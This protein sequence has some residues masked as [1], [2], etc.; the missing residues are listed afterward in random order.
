MKLYQDR[1][2]LNQK[3]ITERLSSLK[4]A[5]IC[6]VS[7]KTI[8]NWLK[9]FNIKSR[10]TSEACTGLKKGPRPQKVKEKISKSSMGHSV[11]Q[12]TRKKLSKFF[13]GR[14]RY[15]GFS[16]KHSERMKNFYKTP[17]GYLHR[18]K[19]S[20]INKGA[21]SATWKGGR[22]IENG[23]ILIKN[24]EHSSA[25]K[26]GYIPEHRLIAEKALGRKLK[27]NELPHHINFDR[28]DNRNSNLLICTFDYNFWLHKKIK[29]LGLIEYF[30]SSQMVK[31]MQ[32]AIESSGKEE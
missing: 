30:K 28:G 4:I 31:L 29:R 6:N 24:P 15:E 2:W 14:K 18:I 17:A 22:V 1:D 32:S 21:N 25:W 9:K 26:K 13:K 19:M 12:A 3:Y 16:Q 10:S 5:K 23:Y 7:K 20:E 8:L 27:R 11:S